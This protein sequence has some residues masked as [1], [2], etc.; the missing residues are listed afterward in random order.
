LHERRRLISKLGRQCLGDE[1]AARRPLAAHAESQHGAPQRE[2]HDGLRRRRPERA[3]REDDDRD[4]ERSHAADAIGDHTERQPADGGA[5]QRERSEQSGGC[6][7]KAE[8]GF[9]PSDRQDVDQK[10]H[11]VEHPAEHRG[12]ERA[13]L[14]SR[15]REEPHGLQ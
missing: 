11:R 3:H 10:I 6:V 14:R 2:L 1:H 13:T 12:E 4:V 5:D 7:A 9:E 8:V 15:E